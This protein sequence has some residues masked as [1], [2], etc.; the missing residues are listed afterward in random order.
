MRDEQINPSLDRYF[1]MAY[2][3]RI[4]TSK[5]R[6][7]IPNSDLC[8]H[9]PVL[10]AGDCEKPLIASLPFYK[11]ATGQLT[12]R[13]RSGKQHWR[14]GNLRHTSLVL[15]CGM[16]GFFRD[17]TKVTSFLEWNESLCSTCERRAVA[18][19]LMTTA[20]LNYQALKRS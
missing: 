20:Q 18:K 4:Q 9:V 13:V 12:H 5:M 8:Q 1:G 15:W 16:H 2:R 14:D 6:S 11:S 3:I 10:H 19:G 7:H 17:G